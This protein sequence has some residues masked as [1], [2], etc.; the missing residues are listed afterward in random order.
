LIASTVTG[1]KSVRRCKKMYMQ[2]LMSARNILTNS[3]PNLA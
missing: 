1:D 2:G 3:S